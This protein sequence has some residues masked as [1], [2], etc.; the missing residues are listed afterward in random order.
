[1]KPILD[2]LFLDDF[3]P[4]EFGDLYALFPKHIIQLLRSNRFS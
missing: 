1:M 3:Q 4:K 2:F